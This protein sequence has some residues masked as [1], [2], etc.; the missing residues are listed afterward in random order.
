MTNRD[1][2]FN[3]TIAKARTSD[4]RWGTRSA[5]QGE[6][7][8]VSWARGEKKDEGV[9]VCAGE[10]VLVW[11]VNVCELRLRWRRMRSTGSC[12]CGCDAAGRPWRG[13]RERERFAAD[14]EEDGGAS[15][16]CCC[17]REEEEDEEDEEEEDV[18]G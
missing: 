15:E 9:D 7:G 2:E 1:M 5:G 12:S 17:R 3:V 16:R 13:W 10:R 11:C 14:R 6:G 18:D 8:C 4:G